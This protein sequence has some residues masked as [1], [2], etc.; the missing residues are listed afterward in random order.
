MEKSRTYRGTLVTPLR[1]GSCKVISD[2]GMVVAGGEIM[3]AGKFSQVFQRG[4]KI[5]DFGRSI[6]LPGLVDT[7]THLPQR[8]IAGTNAGTLLEWLETL[9]FPAEE[10]FPGKAAKLSPRFFREMI[11]SG[12]TSAA[13]YTTIHA[14]S[15]E[16]AFRAALESGMRV[17]MGNML[18]DRNAPDKL[19]RDQGRAMPESEV[20]LS[21]WHGQGD[22]RI[23]YAWT[24]RFAPACSSELMADAAQRSR[25]TGTH[26]QTHLSENIREIDW[27]KELF[28]SA[29]DYT[30]V[31]ERLGLLHPKTILGH[32][33]HLSDRELALIK[34]AGSGVA[35]CPTSN[36]ALASGI[37]PMRR[38]IEREIPFGLGSDVGAGPTL[39]MFAV[40]R[41]TIESQQELAKSNPSAAFGEITPAYAIY[42]ATLGGARALK[43]DR[44]T[45]SLDQGKAAD[46]IVLDHVGGLNPT[47]PLDLLSGIVNTGDAR[48]VRQVF[49]NGVQISRLLS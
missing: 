4:A 49:V 11:A 32:C 3:A 43:L 44:T 1:D 24:P 31:Y 16:I 2:G 37:F 21:R 29:E 36:R 33:I 47:K 28:P 41:D 6:I 14:Q 8:D 26:L 35:H 30:S 42:L 27:V 17:I 25:A 20:L 38:F 34:N 13:V 40:M 12:T 19:L 7:H 10:K 39:D 9:T 22:G 18:M 46:F 23:N 5:N 15:T 48:V 45:G